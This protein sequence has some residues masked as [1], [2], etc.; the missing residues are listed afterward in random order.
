MRP[1]DNLKTDNIK[2]QRENPAVICGDTE[3]TYSQLDQK[4]IAAA[5]YLKDFGIKDA[6][7]VA[8]FCPN[9]IQYVICL[10]AL[11]KL[12]AVAC[13]LSTRQPEE[14]INEQLKDIRSQYL[15]TS[16]NALI[17]SSKIVAMNINLDA[18]VSNQKYA[19]SDSFQ[20]IYKFAKDKD[21]TIIFTSGSTEKP[22][23]VLHTFENHYYNAKGS[24]ENIPVNANDRWLLSLPLY[25][26]SGLGI[27]FRILLG[28]GA[29]VIP[30]AGEDIAYTISRYKVTHLSLVPAQLYRLLKDEGNF[31]ALKNLKAILLGGS[32]IPSNLI[33]Q[34][35]KIGLS[36]CVTYG[37]TEMASQVATSKLI[38]D[39]GFE[40]LE[41]VYLLNYR[42]L[43]ISDQGEVFVKGNTLFKGYISQN[44]VDRPLTEDGWFKTGD[45]GFITGNGCL[46]ITGRKDNMF[47]SGGENIRPEEIE[48]HLCQI[49]NVE[50]AIV[51]PVYNEEYG[52]RPVA[53]V[54][55][56]GHFLDKSEILSVLSYRLPKFMT[57]ERFY[58]WPATLEGGGIK[59]SRQR[60]TQLVQNQNPDLSEIK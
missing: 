11:W 36:L 60:L 27:L 6:D 20:D 48:R 57:P 16:I 18:V 42:Q 49:E 9:S 31:L 3:L 54:K 56:N 14:V 28:Y 10:L 47:I 33:K 50:E 7:R 38:N 59:I 22:K 35:R 46:K 43:K 13:L 53:F 25:H 41:N 45:L 30:Y 29:I 17:E 1:L 52:F 21:A 4:V 37:L 23:A 15:I 24:N 39:P 8:L 40:P 34:S 26:V 19:E 44:K 12:G 32:S 5:T 58:H 51:V 2:S 55:H